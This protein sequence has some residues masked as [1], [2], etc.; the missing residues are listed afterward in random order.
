MEEENSK[1]ANY[2]GKKPLP[3]KMQKMQKMQKNATTQQKM[4][5]GPK[6]KAIKMHLRI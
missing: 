2:K 6:Q 3:K 1:N 4:L 5:N